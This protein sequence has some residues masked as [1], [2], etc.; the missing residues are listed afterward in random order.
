M[1]SIGKYQDTVRQIDATLYQAIDNCGAL[2][3]AARLDEVSRY[4]LSGGGKKLRG[5][6]L[7][8]AC[9]AVGGDPEQVLYAA[10]GTEYGHLA[11]LVHDDLMDQDEMRRGKQAIW[12]AYGSDYAI[13]T[14]DLF[15][16]QAYLCL[17]HCRHTVSAERVVRVLEV[18]SQASID[19]CI[20]QSLEAQM[21]G[22]CATRVEAYLEMVRGKTGSLFRATVESGAILGGGNDQQVAAIRCYG[23]ALG[24]AFQIV[25][26]MLCYTGRDTLLRKSTMSD[27]QNRRVT[28]PILYALESGSEADR[29]LLRQIFGSERGGD[30]RQLHRTVIGILKRTGALARAER[31]AQRLYQEAINALSVLPPNSGRDTLRFLAQAAIRRHQ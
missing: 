6:M 14:G 9:R 19:L 21:V 2:Q 18:L 28:L 8:E 5:I 7:L 23:E 1:L 4:A 25:D 3:S 26:D 10:A 12:R 29:Q 27:V 16:F 15:I 11:S 20:G 22:D 17:A 24:I 13:L 30:I 31:E